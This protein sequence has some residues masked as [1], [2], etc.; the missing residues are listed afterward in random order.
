MNFA[1]FNEKGE[2]TSLCSD[3]NP[4]N[5]YLGILLKRDKENRK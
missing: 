2:L 4:S 5:Q 3:F 1:D